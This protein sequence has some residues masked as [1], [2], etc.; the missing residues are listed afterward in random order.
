MALPLI[1]AIVVFFTVV[2]VVFAFG[3]ATVAPSSV[4]G[5]R[6][7]EIGWQRPKHPAQ[8]RHARTHPAGSRS[9][10]PRPAHFPHRCFP[11][12][13]L[14]HSGRISRARSTSPSTAVCA[15]CSPPSA[16]FSVFLVYRI[17]F[18][19]ASAR[20]D[21]LSAFSFPRFLLK[22]KMQERQRRIR[23][24]LPDATRSHR[25]LRRSRTASR[26]GPD[27]RRR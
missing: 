13:R 25:H 9:P 15:S 18:A 26:S 12:P 1:L 5:S 7:R 22:E 21:S 2:A 4:L 11:N 14:A 6:L 8:A 19:P 10:Q 23:L 20:S 17:Q 27:P 16:S 3:A 24:G